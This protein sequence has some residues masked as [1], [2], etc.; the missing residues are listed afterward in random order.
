MG[1]RDIVLVHH[2]FGAR[3]QHLTVFAEQAVR[4]IRMDVS[5]Q[6]GID[7]RHRETCRLEVLRQQS[8]RIDGGR[9]A[10]T[11]DQDGL[12]SDLDHEGVDG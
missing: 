12:A 3:E 10:A 9:A 2:H 8:H 4:M 11:V 5:E 1:Q 7:V 6:H